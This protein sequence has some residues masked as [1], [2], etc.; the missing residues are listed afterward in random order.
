[1]PQ[2]LSSVFTSLHVGGNIS[3][4]DSQPDFR[5]IALGKTEVVD[6]DV[7]FQGAVRDRPL[8][9]CRDIGP[10]TPGALLNCIE[11]LLSPRSHDGSLPINHQL[12]RV[13]RCPLESIHV[14]SLAERPVEGGIW[15]DPPI[16]IPIV[17]MLFYADDLRTLHGLVTIQ[18]SQQFVRRRATRASLRGE[19]FEKDRHPFCLWIYLCGR[20]KGSSAEEKC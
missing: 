19:E 9:L 5:C 2:L 3:L 6:A 15:I 4:G 8:Q 17:H 13:G 20:S 11:N 1:M 7:D 18:A 14:L 16:V 12:G 10:F